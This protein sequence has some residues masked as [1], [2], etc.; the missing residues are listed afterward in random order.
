MFTPAPYLAA[1]AL[2]TAIFQSMRG[3]AGRRRDRGCRCARRGWP[4]P[5]SPPPARRRIERGELHLDRLAGRRTGA[6]RR[7]FDED[8]GDIRGLLPDRVHDRVARRAV[9]PIGEFE[10][11]D[12][13]G[14]L[15]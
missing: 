13:D 8:A 9:P 14:V 4:P 6:R 12:A 1:C 5:C 2:S 15:G 11:D 7:H 3:A 10:L